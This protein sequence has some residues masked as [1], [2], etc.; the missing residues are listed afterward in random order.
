M[1]VEIAN[2]GKEALDMISCKKYD[3]VLMDIQMPVMDGLTATLEI[4]KIEKFKHLPILAMT[5]NAM[6][7][8]KNNSFAAGMN[9]HLSKPIDPDELF[10]ALM[11]WIKTNNAEPVMAENTKDIQKPKLQ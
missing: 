2:N 6:Q 1:K 4:R 3:I 8:D 11:K 9:D 7:Q 10:S 5:A